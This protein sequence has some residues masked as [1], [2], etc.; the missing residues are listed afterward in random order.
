MAR[1]VLWLSDAYRPMSV[2]SPASGRSPVSLLHGQLS[3]QNDQWSMC[4]WPC[5][6]SGLWWEL[7]APLEVCYSKD[8]KRVPVWAWMFGQV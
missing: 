3:E 8:A 7:H 2:L 5:T 6:P 1:A 4:V